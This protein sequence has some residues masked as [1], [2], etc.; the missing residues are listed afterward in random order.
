MVYGLYP[1]FIERHVLS[2]LDFKQYENNFE[3]N[4]TFRIDF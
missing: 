2:S 1:R 4:N 3:N